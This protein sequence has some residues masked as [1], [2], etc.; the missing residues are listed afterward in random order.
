MFVCRLIFEAYAERIKASNLR[1]KATELKS[2]FNKV[3]DLNARIF[4]KKRLQQKR[5]PINI[6]NL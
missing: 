2:F 6:A 5:L 1:E 3:A 4:I